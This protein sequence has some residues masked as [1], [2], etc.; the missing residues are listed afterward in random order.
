MSRTTATTD[1]EPLS[2]EAAAQSPREWARA[3]L[4]RMLAEGEESHSPPA[5][6]NDKTDK[7]EG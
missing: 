5:T 3:W 6:T 4:A 2:A 1:Q 7:E